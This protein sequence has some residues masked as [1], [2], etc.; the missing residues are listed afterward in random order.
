MSVRQ[1]S[2]PARRTGLAIHCLR[3]LRHLRIGGSLNMEIALGTN[4]DGPIGGSL[5]MEIQNWF[6]KYGSLNWW[7]QNWWFPKALVFPLIRTNF[8]FNGA[9]NGKSPENQ[10]VRHGCCCY[11]M[12][13]TGVAAETSSCLGFHP[14]MLMVESC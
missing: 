4:F 12:H 6:P 5:N 14:L 2:P 8:G 3:V 10:R 1:R 7:F 9:E 11:T 13:P